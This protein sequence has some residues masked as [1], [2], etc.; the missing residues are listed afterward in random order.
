MRGWFTPG[1]NWRL[2]FFGILPNVGVAADTADPNGNGINNLMEYTLGGEPKGGATG[3]TIL[4]RTAVGAG[5]TLQFT[6]TRYA[7]RTDL[8]LTVKAAD[9]LLGPW[10][11]LAQSTAGGPFVV[12]AS[13]ANA[14]ETGAGNARNVAVTDPYAMNDPAHPRRFMRLEVV[15]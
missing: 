14:E 4:P 9:S 11:P 1:E 7:D 15:R 13:G 3:T 5:N 6:F 10:T 12:L 2:Q 8:T